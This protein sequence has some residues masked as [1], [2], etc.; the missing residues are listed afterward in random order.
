MKTQAGKNISDFWKWTKIK[1][2]L[3]KEGEWN[4]IRTIYEKKNEKKL[5]RKY[6]FLSLSLSH[7]GSSVNKL[8]QCNPIN[9][10]SFLVLLHCYAFISFPE[11]E[12]F[13]IPVYLWFVRITGHSIDVNS[14]NTAYEGEIDGRTAK[15][16]IFDRIQIRYPV[17]Q[18]PRFT[19]GVHFEF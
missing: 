2:Q 17:S 15:N 9:K 3:D 11:R 10:G 1:G 8:Q 14:A 4:L 6:H 13:F 18:Y 7:F 5:K 16:V 19:W 12:M